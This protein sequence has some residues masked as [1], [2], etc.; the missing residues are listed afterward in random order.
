MADV[1]GNSTCIKRIFRM[2]VTYD[3]FSKWNMAEH[4]FSD[5]ND[6][7]ENAVK[8]IQLGLNVFLPNEYR[9]FLFITHDVILPT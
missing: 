8:A 9:E 4:D 1:G 6:R 7:A 2:A 3:D 5:G